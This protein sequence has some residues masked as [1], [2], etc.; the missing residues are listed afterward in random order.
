M[1]TEPVGRVN[2]RES[3]RPVPLNLQ[4]GNLPASEQQYR[5]A[6]DVGGSQ[7]CRKSTEERVVEPDQPVFVVEGSLKVSD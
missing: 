7:N 3:Y 2:R 6:G 4:G 5:Q 1:E